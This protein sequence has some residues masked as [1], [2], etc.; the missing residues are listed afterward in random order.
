MG[1]DSAMPGPGMVLASGK[2][3]AHRDC[4]QLPLLLAHISLAL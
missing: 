1:C 2:Q 4:G 3:E